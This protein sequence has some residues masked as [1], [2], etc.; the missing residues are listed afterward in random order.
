[1]SVEDKKLL[2]IQLFIQVTD[3]L[4]L[5]FFDISSDKMLDTKIEVLKQLNAGVKPIDIEDYYKVL[6]LYPKEKI[7]DL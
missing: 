7:W 2:V 1:M 5:N 4:F 6:E 3:R